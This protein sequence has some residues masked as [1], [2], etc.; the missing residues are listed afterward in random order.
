MAQKAALHRAAAL[1]GGQAALAAMLGYKDRRNVS[2]WFNK[3]NRKLIPAEHCPVVE[4]ATE[5]RGDVVRCEELRSD[6]K[7]GVLR[8]R[9][10]SQCAEA[11]K[12]ACAAG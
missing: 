2:R 5:E 8:E 4:Q 11:A 3:K 12:S 10:A 1:L 7:W 6:V 9:T